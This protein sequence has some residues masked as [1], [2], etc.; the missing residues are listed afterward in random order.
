MHS[1]AKH[2]K[3]ILK[4]EKYFNSQNKNKAKKINL[5]KN[6][7]SKQDKKIQFLK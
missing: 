1:L 2:E 4:R 5:P 7:S 6:G 3:S